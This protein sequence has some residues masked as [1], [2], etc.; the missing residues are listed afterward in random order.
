LKV[1]AITDWPIPTNV[2][3]VRSFHGLAGFYRRFVKVFSTI[4]APLNQL[5]KKGVVFK[6]GEPQEKA[7][8]ELKK[9][10]TKAPLLVLPDFTKSFEIKCNASGIWIGGVLV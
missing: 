10:F 4:A 3:Q 8:Q 9:H 2:S 1:K 6:R 5:T 7:F